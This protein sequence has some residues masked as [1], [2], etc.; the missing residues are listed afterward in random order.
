M[1]RARILPLALLPLLAACAADLSEHDY[2]VGHP[3]AVEQQTATA[4]FD[5][6]PEGVAISDYDRLRLGRLADEALRRGAGTAQV[7]AGTKAG[8]EAANQAFALALAA[9]LKDKG[10]DQVEVKVVGGGDGAPGAGVAVVTVPVWTARG[11]ECGEFKRGVNPDWNNAPNSN[12]GCATQRNKALMV[13]NPADLVRA[14]EASGRDGNRSVD[15]LDKYGRGVAVGS[16][17]E[18]DA[19]GTATAT[20]AAGK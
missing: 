6:P 10:V 13:Q 17:K 9:V 18:P 3:I 5:R 16:A 19:Q 2:R 1:S 8:E 12:W 7:I 4:V 20:G 14:R 11:P 15:V